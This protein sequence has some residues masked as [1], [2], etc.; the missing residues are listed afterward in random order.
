MVWSQYCVFLGQY[1]ADTFSCFL[2]I[3]LYILRKQNT[4]FF[5]RVYGARKMHSLLPPNS[6][7]R[8]YANFSLL[9][10]NV[11]LAHVSF[12]GCFSTIIFNT[13]KSSKMLRAPK[14]RAEIFR[15]HT[16]WTVDTPLHCM[17][18]TTWTRMHSRQLLVY[19]RTWN[20]KSL[21]GFFMKKT[22]MSVWSTL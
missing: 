11:F 5:A 14:A 20:S 13:C 21:K 3:S 17:L 16:F 10:E 4:I 15:P 22:S 12:L 8:G 2:V 18:P 9:P 7:F 6:V 19:T 1:S